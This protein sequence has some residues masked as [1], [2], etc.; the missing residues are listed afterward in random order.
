RSVRPAPSTTLFPYTTLFRSREEEDETRPR[1]LVAPHRDAEGRV[2][3]SVLEQRLA[4]DE[5]DGVRRRRGEPGDAACVLPRRVEPQV[6]RRAAEAGDE[7][8]ENQRLIDGEDGERGCR[9]GPLPGAGSR[10]KRPQRAHGRGSIRARPLSS[11]TGASTRALRAMNSGV[12]MISAG[13]GRASLTGIRSRIW[14]GRA[15]MTATRSARKIASS[16][17]W[18]TNS[19][20]VFTSRQTPSS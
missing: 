8:A 13:R 20:V 3:A 9:H 7:D 2:E 15:V 10:R 19:T 4:R 5:R 1:Q 18:V 16:T 6:V 12:A 17:S 14:P 11:R